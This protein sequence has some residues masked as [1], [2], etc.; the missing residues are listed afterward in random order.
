M[1]L[2]V[3]TLLAG[4]LA[5]GAVTSAAQAQDYVYV[6]RPGDTLTS[7]GERWLTDVRKW[8]DLVKP[9]GVAD[10]DLI[11]PGRPLQIPLALMRSEPDQATVVQVQGSAQIAGGRAPAVGDKIGAGS[12]LRTGADGYVT[13]ELADGSRLVLPAQSALRV[14][15]LKRYSN[16]EVRVSRLRVLTGRIEAVVKKFGNSAGRFEVDTPTA[17]IGVRGTD[18]RAG[19]DA[20]AVT[21][22]AEVLDGVVGLKSAQTASGPE[23]RVEA[24]FGAVADASGKVSAPVPLLAAPGVAGLPRLQERPLV[25]FRLEPVAG[26]AAYRAQ[27]L[28]I[29]PPGEVLNEQVITGT[30]L[31]VAD[32]ADGEYVLRL[33]GIDARGLEGREAQHAFKLKA[34]PEPP[35]TS[36]PANRG[37]VRATEVGFAWATAVDA[38]QYRFQLARDESFATLAHELRATSSTAH[39]VASLATGEYF[40]R[41]ASIRVDG[42]QGPFG[43]VQRF[44][45]L[46]PPANPEP[47]SVVG[48]QLIFTWGSEPGQT[49]EFQVARDTRFADVVSNLKLREPKVAVSRPGPGRYYMRLRA[50]DADGFVGPYTATQSFALPNCLTSALTGQCVSGGDGLLWLV[51]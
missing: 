44:T 4:L 38:A 45:L 18:F 29:Q 39:S 10:R 20:S 48:D 3:I 31:R 17:A 6:V 41:V 12:E 34:R 46:P 15:E 11:R 32:L 9:N 40:W 21:L 26:A 14:L 27:V 43:D 30:E 50:I 16:T 23:A 42:D 7:I 35:F 51:Q 47:P 24:G 2:P 25:R 19:T 8:V 28:R 22:R 36:A 49:F 1:R 13:L 37:K 5:T 33:R